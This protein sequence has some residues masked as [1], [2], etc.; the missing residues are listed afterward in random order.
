MKLRIYSDLHNEFEEFIPP[1][2]ND[3][4]VV[5]L[6]GD[7]DLGDRGVLWAQQHFASQQ[8]I[9]YVLGNHE[10]YNFSFPNVYDLVAK[11]T[12][13]SNIKFLEQQSQLV[14]GVRFLGCTLWSDFSIIGEREYNL[15]NIRRLMND[16]YV[17]GYNHNKRVL[18][19][20]D[21][22]AY[23]QTS[24]TWLQEKLAKYKND[25]LVVITH[26]APS[27]KS[28]TDRVNPQAV[29]P[30]YASDLE[31]LIIDSNV[32]L[33]IHGHTHHAWD[34]KIGNT[35][36]ICNP[37]GYPGQKTGFQADLIVKI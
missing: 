2:A 30:A 13:D 33:W 6:A 1:P 7:I 4:D 36:I 21:I 18:Q 32:K 37:R 28:L 19:P 9:F 25:N 20:N 16:Y 14:D 23:H 10:F 3:V 26:H 34:Y 29:W 11:R 22:Y 17:I 31:Q 8:K 24:L 35:R 5:I 27:A 12:Q 15:R